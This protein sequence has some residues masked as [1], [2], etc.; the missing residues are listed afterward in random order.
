MVDQGDGER[1]ELRSP[2]ISGL[3]R[4]ARALT[5]TDARY[6]LGVARAACRLLPSAFLSRIAKLD[7][8][9]IIR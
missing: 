8:F 4:L 1:R 6:V 2:D 5:A 9:A 3:A 7:N